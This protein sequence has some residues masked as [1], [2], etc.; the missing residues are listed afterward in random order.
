MHAL[1]NVSSSGDPHEAFEHTSYKASL[2]ILHFHSGSNIYRC[3]R[4][5]FGVQLLIGKFEKFGDV[6]HEGLEVDS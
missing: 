1:A 3:E 4:R 6:A 5:P 2:A